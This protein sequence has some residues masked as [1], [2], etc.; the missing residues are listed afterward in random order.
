MKVRIGWSISI[1]AV[2]CSSEPDRSFPPPSAD[3]LSLERTRCFGTCPAY[4][5]SLAANG[6]VHFVSRS[7]GD[8]TQATDSVPPATLA[9]LLARATDIGF[10]KLPPNIQADSSLCRL[11]ATDH[12]GVT[13]TVFSATGPRIVDDYLGCFTKDD[14][15]VADA[16]KRLRAFED[17][18]DSALHAGRWVRSATR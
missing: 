2:A 18:I 15:S 10:F 1:L 16:V 6:R 8:S 14:R 9:T 5:I 7:P 12:P 17:E 11:V 4:R 13:L 3:S